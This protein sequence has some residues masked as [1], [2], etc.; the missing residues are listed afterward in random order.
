VD[1]RSI[2]AYERKRRKPV[3]DILIILAVI[4]AW[5]VLQKYILPKIGIST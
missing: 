4:G 5:V 2:T 3:I 1:N